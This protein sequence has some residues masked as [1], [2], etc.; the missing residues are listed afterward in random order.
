[1][2]NYI[3]ILSQIIY[4]RINNFRRFHSTTS[5]LLNSTNEW[6]VNV[7]LGLFNIAVFL[8]LQNAFDTINHD[9]LLK[10]NLISMA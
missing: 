3:I 9:V 1:M 8:D 6:F 4:F 10:K 7:D 2:S 5:A